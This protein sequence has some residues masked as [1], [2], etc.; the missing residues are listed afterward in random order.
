M[1]VPP[2]FVKTTVRPPAVRLL[3]LASFAC[4]VRV[5]LLPEATEAAETLTV[6]VLVEAFAVVTVTVGGVLVTLFPPIVAWMVVAV[7]A[8]EPVNVAV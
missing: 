3:P 1:L 2:A 7:P 6:E 8:V 4:S 5:T